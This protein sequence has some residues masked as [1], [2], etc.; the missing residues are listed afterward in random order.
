VK[1]TWAGLP[2][3]QLDRI[4]L[5]LEAGI[6][7][8]VYTYGQKSGTATFQL[9]SAG[10]YGPVVLIETPPSAVWGTTITVCGDS[11]GGYCF[12]ATLSGGEEVPPHA[13][14]ATAS[15]TFMYIPSAARKLEWRVRHSV[16]GATVGNIQQAPP[17]TN[18]PVIVPYFIPSGVAGMSAGQDLQ[19]FTQ[20]TEEQAGN[21]WVGNL[22]ANILSSAYPN[23]EIR[24][25]I[26]KRD[27]ILY[28]ANL[29]GAQQVPPTP[30]T[31]TGT[32]SVIFDPY[33]NIINYQL[34]ENIAGATDAHIHQAPVGVNGPVIVPFTLIGQ[35]A[36][37]TATLTSDQAAALQVG[38]LYM[39]VT[40]P[41]YPSGEIRGVLLR[42]GS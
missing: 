38:G 22:Y 20:L 41:T 33:T 28:L 35:G 34:Q 26:L 13:T 3:N 39:N 23:G 1:V 31:A 18:G 17:G 2:G 7:A 42:P 19:N 8:F 6:A 5:N 40:S 27:Q 16:S 30:S 10:F 15:A 11:G 24:G 9:G 25:Q 37:G 32:G 4:A 12:V 29:T 36:S 21:L 14:N